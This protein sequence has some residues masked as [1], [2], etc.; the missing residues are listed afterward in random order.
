MD[1]LLDYLA[2]SLPAQGGMI[3]M[4]IEAMLRLWPSA[5][6]RSLLLAAAKLIHEGADLAKKV[7]DAL[8]GAASYADKIIP[9]NIK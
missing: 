4:G 1:H 2:H 5:K 6:P 8:S 9:Q 7:A 3:A